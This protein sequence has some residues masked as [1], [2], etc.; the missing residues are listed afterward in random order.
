[1]R[2]N[3]EEANNKGPLS[4]EG[5]ERWRKMRGRRNRGEG[6]TRSSLSRR[7]ERKNGKGRGEGC[8]RC[9]KGNRCVSPRVLPVPP[10]PLPVLLSV[11]C[12]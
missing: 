2:G 5:K 11:L 3:E 12:V 1:M 6:R 7:G 10:V 4:K 9:H 8:H